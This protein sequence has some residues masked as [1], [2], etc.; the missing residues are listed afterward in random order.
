MGAGRNDRAQRRKP[1]CCPERSAV[2]LRPASALAASRASALALHL[3]RPPP[4]AACW[5][6]RV[7]A[8]S[9]NTLR[10]SLAFQATKY[11]YSANF[12]GTVVRWSALPETKRLLRGNDGGSCYPG[13]CSGSST[14]ARSHPTNPAESLTRSR[15]RALQSGTLSTWSAGSSQA[16]PCALTRWREAQRARSQWQQPRGGL[17]APHLRVSCARTDG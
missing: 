15:V 11:T 16:V 6:P 4:G 13:G 5:R 8:L 2:A 1:T 14:E 7:N 10:D 12:R 3:G 17:C 9:R